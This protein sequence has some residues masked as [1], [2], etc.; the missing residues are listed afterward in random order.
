MALMSSIVVQPCDSQTR[1]RAFADAARNRPSWDQPSSTSP[2]G[3]VRRR[4]SSCCSTSRSSTTPLNFARARVRPDGCHATAEVSSPSVCND[5]SISPV[6]PSQTFRRP[7]GSH[8]AKRVPS[9][10]H[11]IS[12]GPFGPGPRLFHRFSPRL[13]RTPFRPPTASRPSRG[14]QSIPVTVNG[15]LT[16]FIS[17]A[18][19]SSR[20]DHSQSR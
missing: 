8:H 12:V 14:F 18:T 19:R 7:A 17:A 20:Y 3:E 2:A 4:I 6:R 13:M 11:R 15:R 10:L 5:H 16:T 1:V 9:G